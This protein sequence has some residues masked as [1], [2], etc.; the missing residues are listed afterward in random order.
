MEGISLDS[1]VL[2]LLSPSYFEVSQAQ[3]GGG[4]AQCAPPPPEFLYFSAD[5]YEI[6]YRCK[7]SHDLKDGTIKI[8]Q[9]HHMGRNYTKCDNN[10]ENKIEKIWHALKE[11]NV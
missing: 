2:T 5:C 8:S 1:T 3:G 11:S 4:G 6:W 10:F 7:T 9:G